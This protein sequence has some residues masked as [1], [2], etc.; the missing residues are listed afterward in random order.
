MRGRGACPNPP[1]PLLRPA[2]PA[3]VVVLNHLRPFHDHDTPII[4][5]IL[6]ANRAG[7]APLMPSMLHVL[8]VFRISHHCSTSGFIQ[9]IVF[10]RFLFFPLRNFHPHPFFIIFMTFLHH[11]LSFFI[12]AHYCSLCFI[13]CHHCSSVLMYF[14]ILYHVS[15]R[16]IIVL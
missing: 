16:F 11:L 13:T 9:F 3:N 10:I 8:M 12:I 1:P 15:S 4:R 7:G 2:M 5:I 6:F 14:I